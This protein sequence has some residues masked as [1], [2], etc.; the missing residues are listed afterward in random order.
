MLEKVLNVIQLCV[1]LVVG[2]VM[3]IG[4]V[5]VP[6]AL[7]YM[8]IAPLLGPDPSGHIDS[9]LMWAFG[10]AVLMFALWM[11][12]KVGVWAHKKFVYVRIAFKFIGYTLAALLVV[13]TVS[14]CA[15]EGGSG[16]CVPSRYIDC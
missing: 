10:L 4:I 13:A 8:L 2:L 1:M 3:T 15:S 14:N 12:I 5:A 16:G 9:I 6:L 11:A 7:L